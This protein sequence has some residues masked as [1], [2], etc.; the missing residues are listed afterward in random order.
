MLKIFVFCIIISC[1]YAKATAK[2][3]DTTEEKSDEDP[4]LYTYQAYQPNLIDIKEKVVSITI[5]RCEPGKSSKK[6]KKK[7]KRGKRQKKVGKKSKQKKTKKLGKSILK[8]KKRNRKSKTKQRRY[9]KRLREF[10]DWKRMKIGGFGG[11]GAL[12]KKDF[13]F[14]TD[15]F[16]DS[17]TFKQH[18]L[19]QKSKAPLH[20]RHSF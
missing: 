7:K 6:D 5:N 18:P 3:E 16:L 1:C 4:C 10:R 13:N 20:A 12:D 8:S 9:Q 17:K 2:K 11:S 14:W 15:V 19:L